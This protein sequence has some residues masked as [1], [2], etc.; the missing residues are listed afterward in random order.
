M[1]VSKILTH[2][3][4]HMVLK[5]NQNMNQVLNFHYP[6]S[7][8]AKTFSFK[9]KLYTEVLPLFI[10]FFIDVNLLMEKCV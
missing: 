10:H 5:K 1:S 9:T 8:D 6:S 3:R 2:R 7:Y 4:L